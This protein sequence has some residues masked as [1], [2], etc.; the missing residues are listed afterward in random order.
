MTTLRYEA[1]ANEL[2]LLIA[3]G[4]LR[5]GDRLPSVRAACRSHHLSPA[6]VLQAYY[7]LERRGLVEARPKSGYYVRPRPARHLPEPRPTRPT[8]E[9]TEVDISD[10]VFAILHASR[11]QSVVPL[12]SGFPSPELFPLEKLARHLGAAARHMDPWATVRDLPP[13]NDALRRQIALRYLAAGAPVSPQEI[14]ITNGAM[15]AL[16]LC[17]QA[18]AKPGDL[19]AV[20]SPTFYASLQAIE[21][22]QLK[23]VEIPTHPREGVSLTALAEILEQQPVKACLLMLNFQNPLGSRVP[24]D[25]RRELLALLARHD[26][27][28]IEDDVYAELHFDGELLSS[29][30]LDTAGRVLHCGSFAKCLAPGYRVG[31]VAAGRYTRSVE[32]LKFMTSLA[33]NIPTQIALADYLQQGGFE[34]HLRRLRRALADQQAQ[35]MDAVARHFPAETRVSRPEGGYFLWL[36]L[37]EGTDTLALHRRALA[38]GI[39]IAPGPIFSAKREYRHCLRLNSGHPWDGRVEAAVAAL[40]RLVAEAA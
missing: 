5:A 27:P 18:V 10:F 31:W 16:N 3:N 14:V 7:L 33:S 13:G 1:L 2:L 17:L 36:E 35:L 4:V 8:S 24:E 15:E 30:S 20:E 40:G 12:G 37:P 25:K 19:V 9:S 32:R 39:S 29:K 28:L 21:R 22:L 11:D 38:Q 6:T 26:V 23:A 34:P